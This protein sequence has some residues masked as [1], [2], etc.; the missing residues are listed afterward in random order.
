MAAIPYLRNNDGYITLMVENEP[1]LA[2]GGEFHNSGGSDLSY[3]RDNVW[4][5]VQA[6]HGNCFLTPVY[7]ECVEPVEGEFDFTLVDGVIEQARERGCHL[8]LLWFGLWKNGESSYAPSWVK[9]N[10][11]YF[12]MLGPDGRLAESVSPFCSRAIEADKKA[13]VELMRH[14]R[15]VNTD[16]TVVMVQVENEVGFWGHSRDFSSEAETIFNSEIPAEMGELFGK[17]GAWKEAFGKNA[18]S[19]FMAW[20]FS[21]AVGKIAEAGKSVYPL[22]MFVNSVPS[23]MGFARKAG[24]YPSGAPV[25][26]TRE[27]WSRFAPSI[28]LFGPDI[29]SPNYREI[30]DNYASKGAVIVPE[31]TADKNCVSKA[32]FSVAAYNTILFSPFGIEE[33]VAPVSENDSLAATNMDMGFPSPE[34]AAALAEGYQM[35]QN[36]WPQIRKAQQEGRIYAFLDQGDMGAEFVIDGYIITVVYNGLNYVPGKPPLFGSMPR[37]QDAPIGGGFVIRTDEDEFLVCAIS[38]NIM[39]QP[40]YG[41][42][43]QVFVLSKQ[44]MKVT[45]EGLTS[46]RILNGDE[47]N[48][49]A[50]G[51]KPGIQKISYY[52]RK[53]Q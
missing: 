20:A 29:Y 5:R 36:L 8:M 43:E 11:E 32:L 28:D 13:F 27:I 25:P 34:G 3:L 53:A 9:H 31:L 39:I 42:R 38:C 19:Y 33:L 10:D 14:L 7:W 16:N 46:G 23:E 24:D 6:L 51:S 37:K 45:E 15:D 1:F 40:E 17:E 18:E 50:F 26:E 49:F 35:I 2:L 30:T 48:Y 41:S 22:P 21:N 47:R 52:R 44:E 12:Y 4:P